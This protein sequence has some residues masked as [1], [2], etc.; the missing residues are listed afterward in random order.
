[1]IDGQA[2]LRD[3]KRLTRSLEDDLREAY[4][5]SA[6]AGGLK[7]EWSE[8]QDAR[9]TAH[10]FEAFREEAFTQ[11]AVHWVLACVFLRFIEDNS[12]VDRPWLA[13]PGERMLLARDNQTA[14]FR[15]Q[16]HHSD[17]DYLL[18]CFD[19]AATLPGLAGLF[20]RK[21][22]PLFRLP[23]SGDGA[24]A[25]LGFFQKIDPDAGALVNDFTD[26]TCNT[27][28]LGDLY[29]D[30]S[31]AARKRYALLQT[32]E[33]VEQ[34][35][36][37]RTLDPAI[38]EFGFREVRLIDPACG[39]GHFL[40]GTF[41]RLFDLWSRHEPGLNPRA[42]A[43]RALDAVAGV[44]IN[45]FAAEIARFRLLLE[46]LKASGIKRLKDAPDFRI[47]VA[48]GD[49]LLH[50]LRFGH[51]DLGDEE[52][53]FRLRAHRYASEDD[54]A[55]SQILG[56]PYQVV[57]ANPPYITPKDAAENTAYRALYSSCHMKYALVVPFVERC[58]DL[59]LDGRQ[60][61]ASGFV[62]LIVANSFMK[63]EFGRKLIEEFLPSVD[64]THVVDTSGAYIPGHGT[65]T[66]ILFGRNRAPVERI[67]RTVMGIRGEPTR[68]KDP[69][70]GLV[71]LAIRA[72]IDKPGSESAFVS[73]A[74]VARDTFAKDCRRHVV[75]SS[76]QMRQYR[77]SISPSR[78]FAMHSGCASRSAMGISLIHSMRAGK[79]AGAGVRSKA[80]GMQ[81]ASSR[82][83][84]SRRAVQSASVS[85]P[86]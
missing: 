55:L 18:F 80:A 54:G 22:N 12:L 44:D 8:A 74:D 51:L 79:Q 82:R 58:F 70:Q 63:R 23:L 76:I 50:G 65:P 17:L 5:G 73:V 27:R 24:M 16:P 26:A 48:V 20:D 39:S 61:A 45:P 28:F 7:G 71:W 19:A 31:E 38:R 33:F 81:S 15:Q 29:Q 60:G 42:A 11:S 30:L 43:Q 64:L 41:G 3:L 10:T 53:L 52:R 67:V 59:A 32:P 13:G 47:H 36:L 86:T 84:S 34:F 25:L 46:A 40:L 49:S 1:M 56:R 2:L 35:I 68:P 83:C 78:C 66:A 21:H 75:V 77:P 69:A 57:V 37:E 4:D 85:F 6:A 62:G 9:R 14:Y 72:Q